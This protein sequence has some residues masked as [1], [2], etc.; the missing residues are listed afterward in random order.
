MKTARRRADR[1]RSGP[2][3]GLLV[4]SILLAGALAWQAQ[5]SLREKRAVAE[6][7]LRDYAMLAADRFAQRSIHELGFSS[8]YAVVSGLRRAADQGRLP[9][10]AALAT[11]RSAEVRAAR[12]VVRTT[13]RYDAASR[14]LEALGPEIDAPTRAWIGDRI[15]ASAAKLGPNVPYVTVHGVVAGQPR[16]F[17]FAA[18][19]TRAGAP[20]LGFVAE[21][22]AFARRFRRALAGET[23]LPKSLVHEAVDNASLFLRVID[24]AGR[25]VFRAGSPRQPL[26]DV[27]RTFGTDYNGLLDG[28]VIRAAMDPAAAPAL[29]IGGLPRSRLPFLILLLALT[30]GLSLTAML[31]L[32]RE[33]ALSRLRADFVSRVSHELRTPLTQIR[34]FTETLLLDRVRS[35]EERRRCLDIIHRESQ[36]LTHLVENV[37][38]FSRGER[39]ESFV[40]LRELDV[41]PLVRQ[42]LLDFEP[43]AAGRARL[44]ASLPE[45]AVA[46]V[47]ESALR[48]ILL[49]LLDNAVKYGPRG[50]EIDIEVRADRAAVRISVADQGPGIPP[51]ARELVWHRFYRLPRDLESAVAGTGIGLAVVRGL[52]DLLG[53]RAFVEEADR[54]GARFVVELRG[55]GPPRPLL[56]VAP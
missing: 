39:G 22:G 34:L 21:D 28:F 19:E 55:G 42:I 46:Q 27:E 43:L 13:F 5:S 30:V 38:R 23:L 33:Q 56:E 1:S 24:P 50:Q 4:G 12:D 2:I 14:R 54:Q 16:S 45:R 40:D 29:I 36:R 18:A 48:Q 9:P 15:A 11:D 7:V 3:A 10:P 6:K 49:N 47:D 20:L 8:F 53:G 17:V 44:V 37:L 26:L 31:Q 32:R 41:V 25:E 51:Q 35:A 52:T